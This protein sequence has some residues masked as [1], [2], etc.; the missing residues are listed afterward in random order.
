M[1][2]LDIIL[3][4]LYL[5]NKTSAG[6]GYFQSYS[7]ISLNFFASKN[8]STELSF[9]VAVTIGL[10]NGLQDRWIIPVFYIFRIFSSSLS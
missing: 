5:W 3:V 10:I 7:Q 8:R 6:S 9:F 4:P 1:S 2:R